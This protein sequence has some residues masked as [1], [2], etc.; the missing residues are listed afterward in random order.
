MRFSIGEVSKLH[1]ISIHTLRYYDKIGLLKP[2][3]VDPNS[4]YRYY[5][6]YDFYRL[7]RIMGL[8]SIGLSLEKI[9]F[10]LDGT[11][12]E[13]EEM[14]C[15]MRNDLIAKINK[16]NEIVAYL[17]DKIQQIEV[18]KNDECYIEPRIITF[19]KREGYI[20]DVNDSSTLVDRVKAIV[21]FEK[22]NDTSSEI[23]FKPS[24][25]IGLKANGELHL[26]SYLALKRNIPGN[27]SSKLYVL[28]S[29]EY[30]V[31]D[32]IGTKSNI[33]DSYNKLL[34]YIDLQGKSIHNEAIEVL[35]MNS[36]LSS[37]EEEW[38][39]QIQIPIKKK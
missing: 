29:G 27:N 4:N 11:I 22:M 14:F 35:I 34:D 37:N 38:R 12:D 31:I 6:E 26:K 39:T 19:P 15:S 16:M 8:R 36:F 9:K 21:D 18:F 24:R 10:L 7:G 1:N 28:E 2:S 25:L 33:Y 30:G 5:D 3:E 13:I 32:H 23:F 17:D 20:I